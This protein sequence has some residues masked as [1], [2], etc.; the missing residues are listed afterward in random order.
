MQAKSF[1]D[2]GKCLI[3]GTVCAEQFVDIISG[4]EDERQRDDVE[5]LVKTGHD[6]IGVG[7]HIGRA[8]DDSLDALLLVAG[9][10]LVLCINRDGDLAIGTVAEILAELAAH[11]SPACV[12]GGGAGEGPLHRLV[13]FDDIVGI[14]CSA[15]RKDEGQCEYDC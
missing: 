3:A 10:E 9:S 4:F 2:G 8:I 12:I 13:D 11:I 1:N 14:R 5:S 7:A 6:Q 15:Q